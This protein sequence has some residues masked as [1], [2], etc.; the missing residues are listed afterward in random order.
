MICLGIESTAHTLGIG[1]V[2]S[3]GTVLANAKKSFFPDEGIHPRE[4]AVHHT[5]HAMEL[6]SLA[7]A[8]AKI[9]AVDI[10]LISFS[11][12][13]G[14]SP[15]LKV[16]AV[17]AR[18][19]ALELK[20]PILGVNHCVSH[21]EIGKLKTGVKDP[22]IV[23]ASGG[24]TQIIGLS[25]KK[26]RVFGETLDIGIGN[27]IDKFARKVGLGN[28]GGPIIEKIAK[29][30][31]YI[32]MPYSIKG[33][34]MSFSGL[35]TFAVNAFILK[36][37]KIEDVC[38]SLQH[39]AYSMVVEVTE[40]ALSHTGKSEVLLTGGV[41]ASKMLQGMLE[42]MCTERGAKFNVVPV[43][44]A[45]DNGAMIAW[46]GLI[47]YEGGRRQKMTD[48]EPNPKWRTDEVEVGY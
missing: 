4:A 29:K 37:E 14:L 3:K 44:V 26:Y 7:L 33:M 20:K 21:I 8:S 30:G 12:G 36:K 42:V 28:P 32:D 43:D 2:D 19:L 9:D 39:N 6:V 34:D 25:G 41:A 5:K 15:S 35:L 11:Q 17:V 22:I 23:Y 40:R 47:E 46:Q 18:T 38:Y 27:M 16:G 1:I 24:N 31:K 13:P 10:D 45:G 48:T